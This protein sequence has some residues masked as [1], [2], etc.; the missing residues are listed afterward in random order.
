MITQHV[1]LDLDDHGMI[2]TSKKGIKLHY[3]KGHDEFSPVEL[4]VT[5]IAGC[6]F[7]V[8]R[9]ILE[10][11]KITYDDIHVDIDYDMVDEKP[12]R[13]VAVRIHFYVKNPSADIDVMGRVL[14]QTIKSCPVIQ[15][16]KGSIEVNEQLT[17]TA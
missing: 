12:Q 2:A 11:R 1:D 14:N 4:L 15:S 17:I 8:L 13:V 16:V 9:I 7:G 6:S 5:S 10:N 3:G